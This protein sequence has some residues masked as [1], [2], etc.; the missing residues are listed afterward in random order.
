MNICPAQNR[1][2]YLNNDSCFK[3]S[4]SIRNL[5]RSTIKN[6]YLKEEEKRKINIEQTNNQ[7]K[8]NLNE[9]TKI[10]NSTNQNDNQLTSLNSRNNQVA[11]GPFDHANSPKIFLKEST[12]SILSHSLVSDFLANRISSIK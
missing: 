9:N 4:F 5:K 3:D 1:W 2:L 12:T 6:L 8:P 7:S 11:N 10:L